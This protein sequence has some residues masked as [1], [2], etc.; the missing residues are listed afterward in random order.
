MVEVRKG[1]ALDFNKIFVNKKL[2]LACFSFFCFF[3]DCRQSSNRLQEHSSDISISGAFALY[4]MAV[5]WADEYKKIHPEI[6]INIS[7]GGA[8]KGI[9]D[10][11]LQ[12]V[13]IGLVSRQLHPE[14][15]NKGAWFIPVTKDAVV[16]TISALNPQ[17]D[18]ILQKGASKELLDKIFIDGTFKSW[19]E[20]TV[21]NNL[22]VHVYTRS[23]AAGAAES[24]A[25]FFGKHQEDLRGVAVYG[26]PG[27]ELA[28][29][30]DPYGIGYNNLVY[31]YDG[32]TRKQMDGIRILPIDLNG[33]GTIDAD[34]NFYDSLDTL[35]NAIATGKY[36][37]PPARDLYFVTNGKPQRKI[38]KDF[39][40]WVLGDGQSFVHDAGYVNLSKESIQESLAKME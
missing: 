36:P 20:L 19:S 4:P 17:L 24:W 12:V 35:M 21:K 38:V 15:I 30:K 40:L 25:S 18:A 1:I 14:E 6:R 31:L 37:S 13:D 28:V 10:A 29:L 33:N 27:L 9:T 23:D 22:P 16:P 39:I 2:V 7:A 3:T 34:E 26:D 5:M 8:G 11:L 32:K